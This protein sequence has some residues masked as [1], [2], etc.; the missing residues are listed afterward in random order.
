MEITDIKGTVGLRNG[1]R[2]PYFGL[3]VFKVGDGEEVIEAVKYAVS[4][5]YRH[6]DTASLYGNEKG[7]GTA[8]KMC[9]IPREQIFVTSKVWNQDQGFD[10]TLR[11]FDL[12]L[13]LLGFEYLDLYLVHWPVKGKYLE[14]WKALERLYKEGRVRAIGVSNFLRHHLDNL[15]AHSIEIPAVNQ[16][17]FHPRLVQQELIDFCSKMNIRYEAWSPLMQGKVMQV[18]ELCSIAEKYGKDAAQLVLRWSLQKGVITIPK[19][20]RRERILSNSQIFDFNISGEDMLVIDKLDRGERI[21][22]DPDNFDF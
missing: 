8:V 9:G 19:S 7:V 4:I 16:M 21:G 14:T 15:L 2:M 12:S 13:K 6:I 17:E 11:A 10:K 18:G 3:G 1:I 20:V 5:G 22:A